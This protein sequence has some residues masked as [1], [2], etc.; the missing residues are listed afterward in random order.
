VKSETGDGK[1]FTE[2]TQFFHMVDDTGRM[3]V[4]KAG[5]EVEKP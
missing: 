4:L 5:E 1:K 3:R 2:V